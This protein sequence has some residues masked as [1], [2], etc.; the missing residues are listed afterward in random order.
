MEHG[1]VEYPWSSVGPPVFL[2][3]EN[4]NGT[5]A[6]TIAVAWMTNGDF[7]RNPAALSNAAIDTALGLEPSAVR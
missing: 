7:L 3:G 6:K 5:N 4:A 1:F 2:R